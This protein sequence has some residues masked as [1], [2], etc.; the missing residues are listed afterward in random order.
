MPLKRYDIS[1]QSEVKYPGKE[2]LIGNSGCSPKYTNIIEPPST[3]VTQLHLVDAFITDYSLPII[4]FLN[5]PAWQWQ[6]RKK[7]CQVSVR[8]R[9]RSIVAWWAVKVLIVS[10][11]A[12]MEMFAQ[13][14]KYIT[15]SIQLNWILLMVLSFT[16]SINGT[17]SFARR[18]SSPLTIRI[19]IFIFNIDNWD[20][21][22]DR[23]SIFRWST[24][25]EEENDPRRLVK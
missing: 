22:Y 9:R 4:H 21:G 8:R 17:E 19:C 13:I 5:L 3:V 1:I 2:L 25:E 15:V 12:V 20:Q 7:D 23:E 11:W 18:T 10:R 6:R 16:V 14:N 24:V